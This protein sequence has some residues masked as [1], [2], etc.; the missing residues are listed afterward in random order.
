[1]KEEM[2]SLVGCASGERARLQTKLWTLKEAWFKAMRLTLNLPMGRRD[3]VWM[4]PCLRMSRFR[5]RS[6]LAAGPW[7]QSSKTMITVL[8]QQSI[9]ASLKVGSLSE[10]IFWGS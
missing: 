1:M 4:D 6:K 7:V 5:I 10:V 2:E 9:L 8:H 3:F